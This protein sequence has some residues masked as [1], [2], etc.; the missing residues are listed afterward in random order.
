LV[1][2]RRQA[3]HAPLA[4]ANLKD[5]MTKVCANKQN[6]ATHKICITNHAQNARAKKNA[7]HV[8]ARLAAKKIAN[9]QSI[10]NQL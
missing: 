1:I 3:A 9:V 7:N 5:S 4:N 6:A 8:N 2:A 10:K